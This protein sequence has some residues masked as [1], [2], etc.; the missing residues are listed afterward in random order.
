M[1][2]RFIWENYL[3]VEESVTLEFPTLLAL[4][5]FKAALQV[6]R[7]RHN[8]RLERLG[9]EGEVERGSI[10]CELLS[11]SSTPGSASSAVQVKVYMGEEKRS[12]PRFKIIDSES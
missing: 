5:N 4:R 3:L 1:D 10:I 6:Y 2:A 9:F 8:K 7:A 12:K 11:T